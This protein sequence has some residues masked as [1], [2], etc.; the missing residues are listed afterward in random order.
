MDKK[1]IYMLSALALA[2]LLLQNFGHKLDEAFGTAPTPR[3]EKQVVSQEEAG[4]NPDD[5]T[6][7]GGP[8]KTDVPKKTEVADKPVVDKPADEKKTEESPL[9][10]A[11]VL[12]DELLSVDGL[13]IQVSPNT[14]SIRA[15]L[16]PAKYRQTQ[17]KDSPGVLIGDKELPSFVLAGEASDWKYGAPTVVSKSE[18]E[19]VIKRPVLGKN[20]LIEQTIAMGE[21]FQFSQ[22]I[23]IINTGTETI[24]LEDLGFNCGQIASSSGA[25][26]MVAGNDLGVDGY[27]AQEESIVQGLF[28][29][30]EKDIEEKVE[31]A[32]EKKLNGYKLPQDPDK[33]EAV[34]EDLRS[35][36]RKNFQ[37][38]FEKP[39]ST[40]LWVAVKNRYF[41]WIV[42]KQGAGFKGIYAKYVRRTKEGA[43]API[44]VL[45]AVAIL[46]GVTLKAGD[47]HE[48]K[49]DCYAGPQDLKLLSA[50]EHGKKDIMQLSLF[51]WFKVGWIGF[52][53]ELML[54]A[55]LGLYSV[56]G[57]W[58]L[59]IIGLTLIVKA[60]FWRITNKSTESMKKMSSLSPQIKEINAKYK[61]NPQVK[62]QKIMELY[63]EAGVNPLAGCLPLLLQMPVFIALFNSLRGAIELRHSDFLWAVDLSR[64]DAVSVFGAFTIHPLAIA[65]AALMIVQQKVVPSSADPTQ[66]KVMMFMPV[67]M[68]FVCWGMPSGLTLYWT[69]ST[70][71]SILQYYINNKKASKTQ[72]EATVTV[73][74]R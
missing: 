26:G 29:D 56:I 22:T 32:L 38:D 36:I 55:L 42:E 74:A 62:Q 35:E 69:F 33:A 3:V 58:G 65:W 11:L 43:E 66:K 71:M 25:V 73:A 47:T 16:D 5:V 17:D 60:L 63:R 1:T 34:K 40:Y 7:I 15:M 20:L 51:M 31:L 6:V 10:K 23:K 59:S 30:I 44:S 64:P 61:D 24:Q 4:E 46:E 27:D 14:G 28:Q 19:I 53:S 45:S 37:Y 52:V 48:I 41:T 67:F 49:L 70:I 72:D 12:E 2:F 50:M 18:N 54:K 8:E 68:L 21:D 39:E 13:K 57:S 9:E